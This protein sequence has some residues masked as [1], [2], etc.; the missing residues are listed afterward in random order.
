MTTDLTNFKNLKMQQLDDM[1]KG[2]YNNMVNLYNKNYNNIMNNIRITIV[3]K[4]SLIENLNKQFVDIYNK[5]N[6]KYAKL[7]SALMSLTRVPDAP[8]AKIVQEEKSQV[9]ESQ[10][11]Q[12]V[13]KPQ[14]PQLPPKVE[15]MK[16]INKKALLIGINYYN[17]Q[18]QL[19]GCINDVNNMK[20][21]LI[22]RGF[23]DKNIT[24][25]TDNSKSKKKPTRN[26]IISEFTNLLKNG[27]EGDLLY[28]HYSGHGSYILDTNKDELDGCDE[29]IVSCDMFGIL[30]DELKSII[31]SNLKKDV[32][33]VFFSDSCH[34]GSILDLKYQ[35]LDSTQNNN[36]VINEGCN[37]TDGNVIMISG[38]Q[39][40]QTSADAKINNDFQGA[41]TNALL[42]VLNKKSSISWVNL[43]KDMRNEL[44]CS[45][46]EQIP[47]LS[48]GKNI[49]ITNEIC[50]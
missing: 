28:F 32:T 19:N 26:N 46:F 36:V 23:S 35:F 41:M 50:F 37:E 29:M 25:I 18:N 38:C 14:I 20:T 9:N 11:Q 5:L 6:D 16:P 12:T 33:L 17:T 31:N 10:Q 27:K 48:S 15:I 7:V 45:N 44:K 21:K 4:N 13:Q 1:Y 42:C 22:E 40:N 24:L 8:I 2:E 3:T 47:Q 49:D 30:D 43:L 34:S 39:D